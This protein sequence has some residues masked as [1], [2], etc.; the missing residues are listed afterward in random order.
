MAATSVW[1]FEN[2]LGKTQPDIAV[3]ATATAAVVRNGFGENLKVPPLLGRTG[4]YD[5]MSN[6]PRRFSAHADS[7]WPGSAGSS[8]P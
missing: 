3:S 4:L 2:W 6:S 7:S 8:S 1:S 5:S